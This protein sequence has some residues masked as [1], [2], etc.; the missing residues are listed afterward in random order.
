MAFALKNKTERNSTKLNDKEILE[1]KNTEKKIIARLVSG[2]F[3]SGL[4]QIKNQLVID[5]L[6]L[7]IYLAKK[8]VRKDVDIQDLV[9]VAAIGLIKAVK[10]YNPSRKIKLSYYAVPTIDGELRHYI[11]DNCYSIRVSR[12]YVELNARIQKYREEFIYQNGREATRK[13]I[14]QKFKLK[15]NVLD[16]IT[17]TIGAHYTASLDAPISNNNKSDSIRLED[18]I[19]GNNFTD[20]IIEKESL[21]AA[22]QSLNL[23]DQQIVKDHFIRECS[24]S[25]IARRFRITQ[26]QVSRVL[27]N[28][29]QKLAFALL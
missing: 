10:K 12:K 22:I 3:G 26:A 8:Y 27:R 17:T 7:A 9:Q 24:Q 19:G 29:C 13:E 1:L 21:K 28:S 16:K 15:I 11:R 6:P 5:N 18:V 20:D 2:S 25:D 23:R 14:S 4:S